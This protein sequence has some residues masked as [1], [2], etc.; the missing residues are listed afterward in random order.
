MERTHRTVV[1]SVHRGEKV[2][3]FRPANFP[4]DDAVRT[5]TQGV[6]HKVADGNRALAFKIRR[7]GFERQPVR[8]LQAK[9]GRVFDRQHALA[10]VDHFRQ[11]VEHRR[12]TRTGAARDDD[13][14]PAGARDFERGTH[15]VRHRTEVA[16]HVERDRLFGKLT[17][18]D[19]G[20]AQAERRHDHVHTRTVLQA[21]VSQRGGLVDPA[22]DLV[23]DALRDLEQVLFV[24]EADRGEGELALLFD[25]GLIRPVDHDIGHVRIVEQFFER[26]EAEQF[27][28]QHL[29]QRELLAAVEGDLELGQHFHDDRAEF[30]GEILL[31]Q[32]RRRFG[33]DPLEQAR[34]HLFLD[35]VDAGFKPADFGIA[36]VDRGHA[37]VET[38]DRFGGCGRTRRRRRCRGGAF[39]AVFARD[40]REL[41]SA[42]RAGCGRTAGA[43]HRT[44]DPEGRSA[45]G[46]HSASVA[47]FA[48]CAH[49]Q[50]PRLIIMLRTFR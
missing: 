49:S 35:L 40:R 18:R 17:N 29:F 8:L 7:T 36:L 38:V 46:L 21:G 2:E 25:V 14:H 6:L 4:E 28:D 23:H 20:A 31:G 10:R 24:A 30:L 41:V 32:R 1:T 11:G 13:I 5:H 33:I 26:T 3:T 42:A 50:P 19:R 39:S 37:L 45:A 34:E 15:L 47:L 27:V 22:T 12:L 43:L 44:R 9:F 16:Q 48:E